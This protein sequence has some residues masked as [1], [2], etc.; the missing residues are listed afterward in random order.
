MPSPCLARAC[1]R[2]STSYRLRRLPISSRS[3]GENLLVLHLDMCASARCMYIWVTSS[4]V[5]PRISR[6]VM[7]SPPF[8]RVAYREGVAKQ[9]RDA[10]GERPCPLPRRRTSWANPV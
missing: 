4:V 7:M 10:G 6:R 5:W 8:I 9:V 1:T 2:I 3:T